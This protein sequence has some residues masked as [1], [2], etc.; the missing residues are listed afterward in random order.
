MSE[1]PA[2]SS[3]FARLKTAN[4]R[5]LTALACYAVLIGIALYAL[6]PAH[7]YHEQFLLG[8]VLFVFALLILKTLIH[9]EDE[10]ME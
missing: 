3:L 1:K 10:K 5:L 2:Q 6:L 8:L 4:R 9:S 7:T